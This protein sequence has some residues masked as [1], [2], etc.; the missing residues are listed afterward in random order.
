MEAKQIKKRLPCFWAI[1]E[2]SISRN[3]QEM[4]S[5]PQTKAPKEMFSFQDLAMCMKYSKERE[6]LPTQKV[7]CSSWVPVNIFYEKLNEQLY[8]L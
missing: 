3:K 2:D 7:Q 4:I 6:R 8:W 5:Y 1:Q